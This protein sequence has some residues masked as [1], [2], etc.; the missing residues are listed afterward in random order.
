MKAIKSLEKVVDKC[1]GNK[2]SLRSHCFLNWENGRLC[3]YQGV[4]VEL[5]DGGRPSRTYKCE[6]MTQKY[7]MNG[8][9]PP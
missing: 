1:R 8:F 2:E 5:Y 7:L 9:C 6:K 3:K 4:R